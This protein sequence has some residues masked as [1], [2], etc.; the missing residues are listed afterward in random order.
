M[1]LGIRKLEYIDSQN[2]YDFSQLAPGSSLKI[3]NYIKSG[4][5]FTALPFTPETGDLAE[6]W[7][8]DDQGKHSNASFSASIR[9]NKDAFKNTLQAL[10]GRKC[11]W[12]LTLISG[13]EYIIGSR[14]YVPKF[15][16]SDGVSGL[17]SSEFTINI[18]NES[19]H[20]L[21]VNS[22]V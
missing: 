15:T 3:S 13:I 4:C 7:F 1:L 19:I 18:E 14:E 10:V 6:Q 9:R 12:K 8:D 5:Q 16:Y 2:L 22:A 17:S 20:G 21:L 11:V